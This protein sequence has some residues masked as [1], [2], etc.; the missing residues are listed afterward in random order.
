MDDGRINRHALVALRAMADLTQAQ[1]AERSK[2]S[3]SLIKKVE[4][5]TRQMSLRSRWKVARALDCRPDDFTH[6][7]DDE[8]AA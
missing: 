8:A 7:D 3:L 6:W 4:R 2:V 1:L 5:G